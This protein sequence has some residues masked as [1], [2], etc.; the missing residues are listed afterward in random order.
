MKAL[1][2]GAGGSGASYLAEFLATI[3]DLELHGLSRWHS[4]SSSKNLSNVKKITLHECDLTDFS[5]LIRALD[6][7]RPDYIFHLAS[8]ANVKVCF[9]NPLAVFN[10]NV[11]G[12]LNL[13]EAINLLKL[14]PIVQSCGTSEVYGEVKPEDVPIYETHPLS[15]V[16]I[17]AVSKLTQEHIAMSY[18]HC[19]ST[20]VVLT[21]MFTYI[22][23][24][25]EDI[26]SSAF[27]KQVVAIERGQQD[28]LYHGNLE[29]V[30]TII[31]VRDAMECYW[32]ASN[33]CNYGEPYN[34]GG[35]TIISVGDF[36]EKLKEKAKVKINTEINPDLLRPKDV[37]LQIPNSDKFIEATGW[38]PKYSIDES[39]DFL[40]DYYR[41]KP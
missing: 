10:N 12:T 22:N 13:F 27:A 34:I 19:Y 37:T 8:H 21:R 23:P 14:D 20:R 35:G 3:P 32:I 1:I 40:L 38:K 36:I 18:R 9:S 11:N 28:K 7:V 17:Y 39:I 29:S 15:P 5:A 41:S 2:T 33:L 16:N 30:R 24:R 31:D 6:K 4:T 25:R 26:F